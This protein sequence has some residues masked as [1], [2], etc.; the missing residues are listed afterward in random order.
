MKIGDKVRFLNDVGGGKIAGF[1]GKDKQI[2][3]VEDED[4]FQ[5]PTAIGDVVVVDDED[6]STAHVVE[7][8]KKAKPGA[9]SAK[10]AATTGKSAASDMSGKSAKSD[11]SDNSADEPDYDP[12]DRPVTFRAPAEERRGGDKLSVYLAFVPVDIL[13]ISSTRFEAYLVNDCNYALRYTIA[14][15]EG[16]AMHLRHSGE[17]EPNTKVFLEE[18]GRDIL[19]DIE[20]QRVQLLAYK[21]SKTYMPKPAVDVQLRIDTVKFYKLHTFQAN[22]FFERKAL[23]CTIVENDLTPRGLSIDAAKLREEMTTKAAADQKSAK[24]PSRIA[25]KKDGP[26]VVDLHANELL[27]TTAGLTSADILNHQIDVFRRTIEQH[28]HDKGK[29]IVFIHG[30]GEGVLR[31]AIINLLRHFYKQY[32]YQDASFKEYG[33]GA[34]QI[35][36]K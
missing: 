12:A 27:D 22:D 30:K 35:T 23:L 18:F 34:T 8:K 11:L 14:T 32:P 5:I 26:L 9:T 19:N 2:V 1:S 36:I 7:T 15:A 21:S 28:K 25:P 24:S 6:Y 20:R 10:S 3:L 16:A 33:Y 4:G 31:A 13:N 17:V 29:Q